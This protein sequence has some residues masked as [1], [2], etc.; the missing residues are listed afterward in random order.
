MGNIPID[1]SV[2]NLTESFSIPAGGFSNYTISRS[3]L[4]RAGECYPIE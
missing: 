3:N 1:R 2:K 4:P